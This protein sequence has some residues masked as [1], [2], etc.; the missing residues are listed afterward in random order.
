MKIPAWPETYAHVKDTWLAG[1]NPLPDMC[2]LFSCIRRMLLEVTSS[3][4]TPRIGAAQDVEERRLRWSEGLEPRFITWNAAALHTFDFTFP[5]IWSRKK[6]KAIPFIKP[7]ISA[8][9]GNDVYAPADEKSTLKWP[10]RETVVM[11]E[12]SRESRG[13]IYLTKDEVAPYG[14]EPV[15]VVIN[16]QVFY[17]AGDL[18]IPARPDSGVDMRQEPSRSGPIRRRE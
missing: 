2:P 6:I 8:G 11:V 10:R 4:L 17:Q 12:V 16:N 7:E 14:E 13:G 15:K 1:S 9:H 5:D 18:M 3:V